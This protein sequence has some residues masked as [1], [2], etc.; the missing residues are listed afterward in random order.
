MNT[1]KSGNNG[2][3]KEA[4]TEDEEEVQR[5]R[6]TV[7]DESIVVSAVEHVMQEDIVLVR[8]LWGDMTVTKC[9]TVAAVEMDF[10]RKMEV[11]G[12]L[13]QENAWNDPNGSS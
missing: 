6:R 1:A 4:V 2:S 7:K 12:M 3:S 8:R 5:R 11:Y 13:R 10:F 9:Y